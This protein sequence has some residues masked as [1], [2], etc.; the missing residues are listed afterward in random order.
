VILE[1]VDLTNCL[2]VGNVVSKIDFWN[3]DWPSR[4]RR[5]VLC[6][7]VVYRRSKGLSPSSLREAY[8]VLKRRY[9]DNGDHV[10]AGEFHYGE[11]EMKRREYGRPRRWLSWEF[12]YWMLSGYGVGHVRSFVILVGLITGFAGLYHITK[13]EAFSGFSEALRYSIG[14]AALQRPEMPTEFGD[15]QKWL[16][17][18]EAV[19]G[20]LQIALF[21]LAL[22]MR[23]KR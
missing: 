18:A 4:W 10:R 19:F 15:L 3:V 17:V 12:A 22:R 1:N 5:Y 20:P 6:D 9:Q 2:L 13:P 14:V 16:H 23:L 8:Q 11:M 7:E 21:V